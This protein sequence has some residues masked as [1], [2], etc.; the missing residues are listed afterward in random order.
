M[1]DTAYFVFH[2]LGSSPAL[3]AMFQSTARRL[4][5]LIGKTKLTDLPLEWQGPVSQ[6]LAEEEK[7]VGDSSSMIVTFTYKHDRTLTSRTPR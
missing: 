6:V 4:Y 5:Q 1:S 2:H 7:T 3:I